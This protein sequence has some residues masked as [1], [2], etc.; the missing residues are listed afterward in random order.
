MFALLPTPPRLFPSERPPPLPPPGGSGFK[1]L[2]GERAPA[3]LR[4]LAGWKAAREGGDNLPRRG[5]GVLLRRLKRAARKGGDSAPHA[6]EVS[7]LA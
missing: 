1:V 4:L 6:N 7:C 3:L 5:E 2:R